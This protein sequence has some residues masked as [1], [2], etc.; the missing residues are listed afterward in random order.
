MSR[1]VRRNALVKASE[2]LTKKRP[3]VLGVNRRVSRH[4]QSELQ[5]RT[6][7]LDAPDRLSTVPRSAGPDHPSCANPGTRTA[8]SKETGRTLVRP[9]LGVGWGW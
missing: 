8:K 1:G 7:A 9:V 3:G 6:T 2:R 4:G 5:S